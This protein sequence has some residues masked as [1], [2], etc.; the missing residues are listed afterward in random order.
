MGDVTGEGKVEG[1][2]DREGGTAGAKDQR[3]SQNR[4]GLKPEKGG[5]SSKGLEVGPRRGLRMEGLEG[6][7]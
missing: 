5:M 6:S 3:S 4:P 2:G 7:E 1:E